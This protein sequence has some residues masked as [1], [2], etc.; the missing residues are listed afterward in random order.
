MNYFYDL[1][2]ELQEKIINHSKEFTHYEDGQIFK[3]N[4]YA[5][6]YLIIDRVIKLPT[7]DYKILGFIR[8]DRIYKEWRPIQ[9]IATQ[10]KTSIRIIV[11]EFYYKNRFIERWL[12]LEPKNLITEPPQELKDGIKSHNESLEDIIKYYKNNNF[13]KYNKYLHDNKQILRNDYNQNQ[14]YII[15]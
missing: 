2:N 15:V 13:K 14:K 10:N 4:D 1:P 7:N 11:R 12:Y 9:H 3:L 8:T 5:Y 6:D